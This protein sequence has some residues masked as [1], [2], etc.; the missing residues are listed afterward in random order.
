MSSTSVI[1]CAAF[2]LTAAVPASGGTDADAEPPISAAGIPIGART[3]EWLDV[4]RRASP[5]RTPRPL[6]SEAETRAFQRYLESF[7]HP[8]PERFELDRIEPGRP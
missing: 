7:S 3:R 4:Q 5:D 8:I 6:P 1:L 2:A